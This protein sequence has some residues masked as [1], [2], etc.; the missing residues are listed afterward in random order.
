V[1]TVFRGKKRPVVPVRQGHPVARIEAEF[2]RI[3]SLRREVARL[4]DELD[5]NQKLLKRMSDDMLDYTG[6]IL[7]ESRR[8]VDTVQDRQLVLR[9]QVRE[10]HEQI[11]KAIEP[12]SDDDLLFLDARER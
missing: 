4:E 5:Y 10:L 1:V 9:T 7:K 6:T 8:E 3:V 12:F 11:A 2:Q